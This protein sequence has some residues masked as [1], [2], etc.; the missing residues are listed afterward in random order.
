MIVYE[1]CYQKRLETE[2]ISVGL[3]GLPEISKIKFSFSYTQSLESS[4]DSLIKTSLH[5]H[6][7]LTEITGKTCTMRVKYLV[8]IGEEEN[9]EGN[10]NVL[11][12]AES[13]NFEVDK[14]LQ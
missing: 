5:N 9:G 7:I 11:L 6:P 8:I 14:F 10:D 12:F 1:V 2:H 4:S 13:S 3:E